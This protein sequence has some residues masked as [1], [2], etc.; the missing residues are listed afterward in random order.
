MVFSHKLSQF[1]TPLLCQRKLFLLY[2]L[3]S[4]HF[5]KS[6]GCFHIILTNYDF[7][8]V[9]IFPTQRCTFASFNK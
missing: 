1:V 2:D 5:K 8:D 7:L 6:K 9:N 3:A 4:F